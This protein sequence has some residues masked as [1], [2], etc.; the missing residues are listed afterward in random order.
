MTGPTVQ[1]RKVT[2]EDLPVFFDY[3]RDA[4]AVRMAAFTAEDPGDREAFDAQ[5]ERILGNDAVV[6]RT[7]LYDGR[8]A[9]NVMSFEQFG[10]PSVGYWIGREH[11]GKGVATRALAAF[12]ELVP[13]RPLYARVAKDNAGSIRV[14][15]K[16][17]FTVTGEERGY[18]TARGTHI[19]ELV[20]VLV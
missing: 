14:L 10:E 16:C 13:D 17:G 8:V 19:D 4:E 1:L 7:V 11:W 20:L 18:A 5:W 15:E 6:K 3:H 2:R 9:G 12:L